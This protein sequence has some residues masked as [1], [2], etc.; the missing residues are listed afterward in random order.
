MEKFDRE[1]KGRDFKRKVIDLLQ[2][3]DFAEVLETFRSYPARR[4]INPLF[5]CLCSTEPQI[6]WRAVT[7]MGG[8]VANL[9]A[10]WLAERR[11][12]MSTTEAS[13]RRI[14]ES[15]KP[16]GKSGKR[17]TRSLAPLL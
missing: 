4:V 11:L 13:Q 3:D 15:W 17:R 2:A 5:S 8:V 12:K 14:H 16:I 10:F 9:L 7:A 1:L 6:K